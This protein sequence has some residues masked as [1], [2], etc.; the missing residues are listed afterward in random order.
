[1][2]MMMTVVIQLIA[3]GLFSDCSWNKIFPNNYAVKIEQA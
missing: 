1:M 2:M 3:F